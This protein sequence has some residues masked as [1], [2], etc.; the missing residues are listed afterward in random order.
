VEVNPLTAGILLITREPASVIAEYAENSSLFRL[1][2]PA[3]Y[4]VVLSRRFSDAF[5]VVNN[6]TKSFTG[7]EMDIPTM[8]FLAL[9]G[10]GIYQISRGNFE[11]PAWYTAFWYALG[12]L[13]GSQKSAD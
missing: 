10:S 7:G 13:T 2:N 4:P 9:L 12:V 6:K 1:R 11:A 8:A 3:D 5:K